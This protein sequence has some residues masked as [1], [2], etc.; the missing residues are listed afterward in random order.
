MSNS[1]LAIE[2]MQE[3]QLLKSRIN[4][5]LMILTSEGHMVTVNIID[6]QTVQQ[7]HP[8][9]FIDVSVFEKIPYSALD[10]SASSK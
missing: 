8:T 4:A 2:A 1:T 3:L 7:E 6:V 5:V 10:E 9:P